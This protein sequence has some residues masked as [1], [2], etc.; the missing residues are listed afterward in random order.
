MKK[1]S[2]R[3][4]AY[5][6]EKKKCWQINVQQG[7]ERKSF[8]SSTEGRVGKHEA[9]NKAEHWLGMRPG[10]NAI[11]FKDAWAEFDRHVRSTNGNASYAKVETI[12]RIHIIPHI[13]A[14]TFISDIT[15]N[16]WKKCVDTAVKQGR[17]RRTCKNILTTIHSFILFCRGNRW[18]IDDLGKRDVSIPATTRVGKRKVLPVS[19]FKTLFAEDTYKRYQVYVRATYINAWRL[20]VLA[21]MRR[22]EVCG[23][24]W[25]DIHENYLLVNRSVNNLYEI[26]P[27]KNDNAV[28][29][30]A[31]GKRPLRV[32]EDQRAYL[33]QCGIVSD[34]VFP[35]ENP[36]FPADSNAVYKQWYT[37]RRQHGI[38]TSL[39]ELRHTF[40][41]AVKADM[42]EPL[43]KSQVGHSEDM[44]TYGVYGQ[45]MDGD[46]ET[47]ATIIDTVFDRLIDAKK[48]EKPSAKKD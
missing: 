39:H 37:Y 30:V 7:G 8:Y 21:G 17:A 19:G 35:C 6:N 13:P 22:G 27:C 2:R 23:L 1:T 42:P 14:N 33:K 16:Q 4:E 38:E 28:R 48:P 26:T 9:E 47:T 46:I 15:P 12:G 11:R 10:A 29:K 41:S 32:L 43:L 36:H 40:V 18:V 25:E 20:A 24:R 5:W 34:W 31:L 45:E 44:D 3:A